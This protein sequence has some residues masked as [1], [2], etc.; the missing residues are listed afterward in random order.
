MDLQVSLLA[1][2]RPLGI[3]LGVVGI[4]GPYGR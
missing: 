4:G 3:F 1:G 2:H